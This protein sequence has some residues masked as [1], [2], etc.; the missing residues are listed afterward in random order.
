MIVRIV[1]DG[2][3]GDIYHVYRKPYGDWIHMFTAYSSE[4]SEFLGLDDWRPSRLIPSK[5]K[6]TMEAVKSDDPDVQG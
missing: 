6:L 1:Q 3:N 5:A 4:I 2:I